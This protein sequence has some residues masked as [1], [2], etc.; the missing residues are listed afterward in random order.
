MRFRDENCGPDQ[1][2]D[3]FITVWLNEL[4]FEQIACENYTEDIIDLAP[5]Y[6]NL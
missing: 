4:C 1:I 5:V 3:T 6:R 2:K